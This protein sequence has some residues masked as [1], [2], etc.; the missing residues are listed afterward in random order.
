MTSEPKTSTSPVP[1][2]EQ[3][4]FGGPM[5]YDYGW[6]KHEMA[7]GKVTF[8]AVARQMP[9]FLRLAGRMAWQADRAALLTLVGAEVLHG[10]AAA[11]ALIATNHALAAPI[12]PGHTAL[13]VTVILITHR[14]GATAKA[15]H[16]FVLDHGR[17][18][19]QG[20]HAEPMAQAPA[21]RYPLPATASPTSSK[22]PSTSSATA[23]PTR[24]PR[25]P[26]APDPLIRWS[27]ILPHE[28]GPSRG[29]QGWSGRY[30]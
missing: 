5:R 3:L 8:W 30:R 17:L 14:L 1:D 9:H 2:S 26:P 18:V 4:L 25:P 19:E 15:D 23:C 24:R 12:A 27:P 28:H 22:P 11:F 6:A 20:T 16:I 10:L 7:S 29:C 13:G 21:T